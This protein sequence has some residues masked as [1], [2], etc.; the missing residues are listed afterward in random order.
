MQ[1][2]LFTN[3]QWSLPLLIWLEE[4]KLIKGVVLTN[5]SHQAN[6]NIRHYAEHKEIPY[7]AISNTEQ[8]VLHDWMKSLEP[9]LA[10]CF[11]FPLTI[12]ASILTIPTYGFVNIHFGKL[13]EDAGPDPLF[14]ILRKQN[15]I[16]PICYHF[17]TDHIDS[18]P[19]IM[20]EQHTIYPGENYGLLGAR[21]SQ[22]VMMSMERLFE[23]VKTLAVDPINKQLETKLHPHKRP[24]QDDLTIDWFSNS[25]DEIEALVNAANPTYGGAISYLRGAMINILEVSPAQ[26]NNGAL[27][28]P[29][30]VVHA[31]QE[32]GI[33][34]LCSDYRFLRLNII[35]T[36]ECII[37]GG[38]L[39][40][41]GLRNGEKFGLAKSTVNSPKI[42]V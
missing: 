39:A 34:V 3:S 8:A 10:I 18:G 4:R 29:G 36:P 30:S 21:L 9:D 31:D 11:T 14:W 20:M 12:Q 38:K 7:L 35:R 6:F 5:R 13:P 25:S 37:S 15:K 33:F 41:L 42:L 23:K 32:N 40:A 22:F 2:I 17:M 26:V 27:I 28:T 24:T 1:I 19:V 16:V